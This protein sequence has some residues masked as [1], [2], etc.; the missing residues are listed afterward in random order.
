MKKRYILIAVSVLLILGCSIAIYAASNAGGFAS[1]GKEFQTAQTQQNS[2][3]AAVYHGTEI[4]WSTVEY[5]E[6]IRQTQLAQGAQAEESSAQDVVDEIVRNLILTEE[7]EARGLAATE[8]EIE[9]KI[10]ITRQW[11][12]ENEIV[13]TAIDE[14]CAGAGIDIDGY[15]EL[16]RQ[17]VPASIARAKLYAALGEEYCDQNG[18]D[19]AQNQSAAEVTQY[20]ETYLNEL[21]EARQSDAVS[22]VE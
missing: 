16:L 19:Y 4:S 5:Y 18:L 12:E 11:Y 13:H 14:F 22:F 9:A 1:I 2:D 3:I 7:A 17:Q 8:D 21:V 10:E 6:K 15:F 20:V